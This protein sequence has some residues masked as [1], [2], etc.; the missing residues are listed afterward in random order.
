MQFYKDTLLVPL[1]KGAANVSLSMKD[2]ALVEVP[3]PPIEKQRELCKTLD[4]Y[5]ALLEEIEKQRNLSEQL[6]HNILRDTFE[7]E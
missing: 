7:G 6:L 3:V 2:I 1:M 4:V 5:E